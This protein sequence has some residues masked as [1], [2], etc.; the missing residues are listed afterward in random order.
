MKRI[1]RIEVVAF[2]DLPKAK[3]IESLA[4]LWKKYIGKSLKFSYNGRNGELESRQFNGM[5]FSV[6]EF[7]DEFS[8]NYNV[9]PVKIHYRDG[10]W[11]YGI[12]WWEYKDV[13]YQ[14]NR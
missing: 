9:L 12:K 5:V 4:I 13:V 3:V 7:N 6:D 2:S 11:E 8:D 10:S 14:R 1:K